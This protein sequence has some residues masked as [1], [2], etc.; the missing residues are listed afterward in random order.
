MKDRDTIFKLLSLEFGCPESS[1]DEFELILNPGCN[2]NYT[3][4]VNGVKYVYRDANAVIPQRSSL[5]REYIVHSIAAMQGLAPK[6]FA[7]IVD[8]GWKISE[9]AEGHTLNYDKKSECESALLIMRGLHSL[10]VN[11]RAT[12]CIKDTW[13]SRIDSME[14]ETRDRMLSDEHFLETQKI[15]N[16]LWDIVHNHPNAKCLTHGDFRS[17]NIIIRRQYSHPHRLGVC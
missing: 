5:L 2:E 16:Q 10:P 12:A 1:I 6:L 8:D 3:F 9:Y 11:M 17:S 7:F 15:V 14:G 13:M 4:K